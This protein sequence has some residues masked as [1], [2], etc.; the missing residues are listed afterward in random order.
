MFHYLYTS[1]ACA[2]KHANTF[3]INIL[4]A[5]DAL[6]PPVSQNMEENRR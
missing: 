3:L 5:I 2:V 6:S 1:T 4:F